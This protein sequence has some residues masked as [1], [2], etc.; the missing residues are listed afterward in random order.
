MHPTTWC[1]ALRLQM[2]DFPTSEK[3]RC[4]FCSIFN[5]TQQTIPGW[6][7]LSF[8]N[9]VQESSFAHIRR[10]LHSSSKIA[11]A[12]VQGWF[13]DARIPSE[14]TRWTPVWSGENRDWRQDPQIQAISA[15]CEDDSR[16]F[17]LYIKSSRPD[18]VWK[19][20]RHRK[21][22]VTS[23]DGRQRRRGRRRGQTRPIAQP[24]GG[25]VERQPDEHK[26]TNQKITNLIS[27]SA[28][29]KFNRSLAI[30]GNA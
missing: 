9:G 21:T 10:Y 28:C 11:E 6:E 24:T 16:Q 17:E 30:T 19:G 5:D 18:P 14:T 23:G 2:P 26:I 20:G 29:T 8:S 25:G 7:D 1:F 22:L 3:V 13:S 27:S 12:S 4:A 15:A